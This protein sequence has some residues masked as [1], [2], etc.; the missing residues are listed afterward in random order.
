VRVRPSPSPY[1]AKIF[2]LKDT[3]LK[4]EKE[5]QADRQAKLIVEYTQKEFE[6]FKQRAARK[7][8]KNAK[9]PGF[10]PGKAPYEVI[11]NRYGEAAILQE[12][13]DILLD[14]DYGK[15]LEKAEIEPSGPGNLE[16]IESFKPPKLEFVVPLEPEVNLGNYREIRKDYHLKDFDIS[17]VDDF[18]QS[19]RKNAA[20]IVPADHPAKEGDLVYFNLTGEILNPEEDED[21]MITEK[22]SQ[23]AVI[24]EKDAVSEDEWPFSGFSRQLIGLEAGET[25]EIQHTYQDQHENEAY[26]GR[27]ALFS[28]E[29]QSVKELELPEFDEEFVQSIGDYESPEDFRE[30]LEEQLRLKHQ[31]SYDRTYFDE[32]LD[33]ITENSELNY[34]PQMLEHEE[35]HVLE[36][37]KSRLENQKM[38]FKTYLSLR[39]MEEETFKK[40]EVQPV[41]KER[42]ERS[43]VVDAIIEAE[44]LKL[45]QERLQ[46]N[47]NDVMTEVFYS[48][49]AQEMQKQMGKDEFSRAISL[50]GMQRTL[51]EQLQERL[52]LIATDQPIPEEQEVQETSE[53]AAEYLEEEIETPNEVEP[54]VAKQAV[55]EEPLDAPSESTVKEPEAVKSTDE[56]P[57]GK[58][59]ETSTEDQK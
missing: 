11:V 35:E 29:V 32:L 34:P 36:D 59:D 38:D 31:N 40:E 54:A 16:K 37:I 57:E 5:V 27:T 22:T 18:I 58:A 39:G 24:P 15:I 51:N 2:I 48:G 19:T 1:Q 9:I 20:T 10:R 52:K 47:I 4:I 46:E 41:A 6:G 3:P 21:A 8:S 12:A 7:I 50:E 28:I 55:E 45:D 53:E 25:K 33:E 17:E 13:I 43:L 26:R 30:K 49:D 14:D 23:Q 56:E 42:L 44:G